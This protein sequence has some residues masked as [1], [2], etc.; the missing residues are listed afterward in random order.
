[1]QDSFLNQ[2]AHRKDKK[3]ELIRRIGFGVPK[4]TDERSLLPNVFKDLDIF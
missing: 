3:V 1:M 2:T 4:N